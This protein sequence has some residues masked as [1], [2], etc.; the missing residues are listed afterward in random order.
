M[1]SGPDRGINKAFQVTTCPSLL[2][3]PGSNL[4]PGWLPKSIF[5]QENPHDHTPSTASER[6]VFLEWPLWSF[7]RSRSVHTNEA[8]RREDRG[9]G[10]RLGPLDRGLYSFRSGFGREGQVCM[11]AMAAWTDGSRQAFL[12]PWSKNHGPLAEV[13]IQCCLGVFIHI[14]CPFKP[15]SLYYKIV[16]LFYI[17][18]LSL[19]GSRRCNLFCRLT[20]PYY[21]L[22]RFFISYW[23]SVSF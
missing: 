20:A 7:L 5:G 13:T 14:W 8:L 15:F 1:F 23:M 10:C 3:T 9:P 4:L 19:F 17:C 21:F 16:C 11:S 22:T 6:P 12:K 2:L 18:L